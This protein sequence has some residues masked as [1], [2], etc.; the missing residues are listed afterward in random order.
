MQPFLQQVAEKV[1]QDYKDHMGDVCIVFPN[2]RA[3]LFF[4]NH[5]MTL[6]EVPVWS[7]QCVTIN[8]LIRQFSDIQLADNFTLI[9]ELYHIFIKEKKSQET[10]DD[11]YFW[12]DLLLNDFDDIDKYLADA[13][14]VFQNI[15]DLKSLEDHFEYLTEDQ[16]KAI[17]QFWKSFDKEK[18][19]GQ[20]KDF[21]RIWNILYPVYKQLRERLTSLK[22]GYEGMIYREVAE[23][24]QNV[25]EL[26]VPYQKIVF[27]GFNALNP[28]EELFFSYLQKKGK[29]DFY[30][31]YDEYYV[32]NMKQEAGFF[33]REN[34]RKF[35]PR[36]TFDHASLVHARDHITIVSVPSNTGQARLLP[37][38][39][40]DGEKR[41]WSKTAIILADERLLVPVL[42]SISEKIEDI[43]V[44]MGYPLNETS[45]FSFI[46]L[47]LDLHK[48][49]RHKSD[50]VEYYHKTVVALLQHPYV[51]RFVKEE[52]QQLLELTKQ[53]NLIY[54]HENV[55]KGTLKIFFQR[56]SDVAD[57]SL[58]IML[59]L[60]HV[61]QWLSDQESPGMA[62]EKEFLYVVYKTVN[63]LNELI[64]ENN[65][66]LNV[67]TYRKILLRIVE[68]QNVPFMG[69]PLSGIQVMGILET[70]CLDFDHV[71]I[72]SMNEGIYPKKSNSSSY[73][74]YH[75][76]KGFG[77]PLPEYQ[78]AIYSYYFYRLL[79]RAEKVHVLY[80]SLTEGLSTGEMS[81]YL[82]QLKYEMYPDIQEKFVQ[83]PAGKFR[84]KNILVEKTT[85]VL[86]ELEKYIR[87]SHTGK[88]F[89]P[90]ALNS[91]LS[92]PLKFY[93]RYIANIQEPDEISEEVDAPMFGNLLHETMEKVYAPYADK[94][95]LITPEVLTRI[96][97]NVTLIEKAITGAFTSVFYMHNENLEYSSIKG[98]N[99]ILKELVKKYTLALLEQDKKTTPFQ[100][101][102]LERGLYLDLPLEGED[103]NI[104]VRVGGKIDRVDIT[105]EGIRVIDYKT[106]NVSRVVSSIEELFGVERNKRNNAV[107]QTF[108]Y[109]L[110]Y[111]ENEHPHPPLVP[112][113][114]STKEIF[115]EAF[116]YHVFINENQKK[117]SVSDA[118]LYIP[119]FKDRLKRLIR[120]ILQPG[121]PF[122]QTDD[123]DTCRTCAYASVCHRNM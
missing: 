88:Y 53:Q 107:F 3:S 12:G 75:L 102:G 61:Y 73:I 51:S 56:I 69:E 57:A 35:P 117:K 100:I 25:E 34:I 104:S 95:E 66:Q 78:E 38:L 119:E 11:F 45:A 48:D 9:F 110:L 26:T 68:K 17:Q 111:A 41:D 99:G 10:F 55:F 123:E 49:A 52:V 37:E 120:E 77:L 64:A 98:L 58:H 21:I 96:S 109:A 22:A 2:Q 63:R 14:D 83:F 33:I 50:H 115:Q 105:D 59:I 108:F 89:S 24:V 91:Y 97:R 7:P 122:I 90:S 39:F 94:K 23:R 113:I 13:E 19:S 15:S 106:G 82:Y 114:Y 116:D 46:R 80:N 54:I 40:A 112:C 31:D 85:E 43:N 92:C 72:L 118:S 6:C 18:I 44:T 60:K 1:F 121:V 76:R 93:F 65:I 103:K 79:Q 81:R 4:K 74:P 84:K 42:T 86:K 20:Q 29:A 67:E 101:A 47:W 70:R 36:H 32:K 30:W 71:V 5:L 28:C 16:M 87:H 62:F 27:V 8:E